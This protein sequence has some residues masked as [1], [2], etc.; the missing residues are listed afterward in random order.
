MKLVKRKFVTLLS[1]LLLVLAGFADA[2]DY[3]Q[4]APPKLSDQELR[5]L[6]G[7]IAL[8]PDPLLSQI[9]PASTYPL[10]IVQ[11]SRIVK[12]KKDFS[13]IEGQN[14]D[15]SVK[16]VAHYP[17]VLKM[18]SERLDWTQQ[19]GQA[20][21]AQQEDV[22][23]VVQDMR[24]QAQ[25][26]G[27]LKS[28]SK[29]KIVQGENYIEIAPT[30]P[31]VIYVPQYDPQIV[32]VV[33]AAELYAP[34]ITFSFGFP[35]FTPCFTHFY[36]PSYSLFYDPFYAPYYYPYYGYGY[37]YHGHDYWHR[38]GHGH[39]WDGNHDGWNGGDRP[40]WDGD[41]NR[42]SSGLQTVTKSPVNQ[43]RPRWSHDDRREN[44][45][46]G[47]V[48]S[49]P[50]MFPHG[51]TP[52]VQATDQPRTRVPT[53]NDRFNDR[54]GTVTKQPASFSTRGNDTPRFN[55]NEGQ[56]LRPSNSGN[57][58]RFSDRMGT[59]TK[60]QPVSY[61]PQNND[62]QSNWNGG[63]RVRPSSIEN[64]MRTISKPRQEAYI[65]PPAQEVRTS[66]PAVR[67]APSTP[68]EVR[69]APDRPSFNN[70]S[71]HSFDR[72]GMG[73]GGFGGGS[74]GGFRTMS[75]GGFRH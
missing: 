22:L 45:F 32:Y 4:T 65:P 28:N 10:E 51:S 48:G 46:N 7:P 17:D 19:L 14:W 47:R 56:R 66:A 62:D 11:A 12:N 52:T 54:M 67:S 2:Q 29:Q 25:N 27:N 5:E 60:P 13:K 39:D 1:S 36:W 57:S 59:I 55:G 33:P 30:N 35:F 72:G 70:S 49:N 74:G 63:Q 24:L 53:F 71:S 64:S 9:L 8:Y 26:N 23:R 61:S 75:K 16:A 73:G 6:V 3:E 44:P 21:M 68:P 43:D 37:G 34:V 41:R 50:G 20:V 38:P 42:N 15:P 58:D 31:D 40:R 69:R 18:M